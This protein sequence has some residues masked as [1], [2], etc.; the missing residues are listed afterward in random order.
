MTKQETIIC[1]LTA[2]LKNQD[3]NER[4][5]KMIHKKCGGKTVYRRSDKRDEYCPN[6][7]EYIKKK[8]D[9][10]NMEKYTQIVLYAAKQ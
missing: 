3:F 6:C 5:K 10:S 8:K 1:H 9:K 7:Q 2:E 4:E